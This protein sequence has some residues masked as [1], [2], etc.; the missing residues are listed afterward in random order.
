M[1]V[2]INWQ[3]TLVAVLPLPL[4]VLIIARYGRLIHERYIRAQDAFGDMNDEVLETISGVRVIR[5]FVQEEASARKLT[6]S[7]KMYYA[8]I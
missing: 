7:P 6:I 4:I 5:A 3:L 1:I 8:K 2:F